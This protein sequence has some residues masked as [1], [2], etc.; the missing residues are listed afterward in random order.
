MELHLVSIIG[1]CREAVHHKF[2]YVSRFWELLRDQLG[3]CTIKQL[4]L[5]TTF[6]RGYGDAFFLEGKVQ[7]CFLFLFLLHKN[8]IINMVFFFAESVVFFTVP[9]LVFCCVCMSYCFVPVFLC[10]CEC[11]GIWNLRQK[12][13]IA[14]NSRRRTEIITYMV[15]ALERF[16]VTVF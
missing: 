13:S 8:Y 7:I 4:P 16:T 2:F 3:I 15:S 14:D 12:W 5:V 1:D 9:V 10:S 11:S 6:N